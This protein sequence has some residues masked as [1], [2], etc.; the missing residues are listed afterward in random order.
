MIQAR[1]L[2]GWSSILAIFWPNVVVADL[3]MS[4]KLPGLEFRTGQM[5]ST[6]RDIIFI[7]SRKRKEAK[8]ASTTTSTT[9]YCENLK[10][11]P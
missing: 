2:F 5:S 6:F 1:S 4:P 10:K 3:V 9:G 8:P 7:I 11:E